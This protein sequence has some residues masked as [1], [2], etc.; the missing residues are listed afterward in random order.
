MSNYLNH[1]TLSNAVLYL[2]KKDKDLASIFKSDGV[3]PLWARRPGFAT[4]IKIILEQQV[5]LAS[6]KAVY[7]RV[8]N[9]INP[10][11]PEHID[12]L[13]ESYLRGLG[14]TR[15]KSSYIMN[16]AKTIN[17]KDLD[18]KKLNRM[19]DKSVKEKLIRIKG[20]GSWT[21]DIYL[22]MVLRRPDIW[23]SGDIALEKTVCT[24]KRLRN[25][26]S[27]ERI[28]KVAEQWRPFRTV[29]A[30]MLWHHYL[31]NNVRNS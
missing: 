26:P 6:A 17:I 13:G 27:S 31:S 10:F 14:V 8:T 4:L 18:L 15:Q 30:R 25:N 28:L 2:T 22:L 5:S 20:I 3:P 29:A 9:S 23:P 24:L 16:I 12:E 19:D 11:T 21:A 1:V 7:R